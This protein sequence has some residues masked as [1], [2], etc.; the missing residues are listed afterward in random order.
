MKVQHD[1]VVEYPGGPPQA[2]KVGVDSRHLHGRVGYDLET[3]ETLWVPRPLSFKMTREQKRDAHEG[4]CFNRRVS[5]SLALDREIA[6]YNTAECKAKD[7]GDVELPRADVVIVFH[8]E[9]LSVLLRS[10]HSILNRTPPELLGEIVLFN[11][12]SN[13]TSHSWL[14]TEL[15]YHVKNLPKTRLIYGSRRRGLMMARIEGTRYTSSPV[16]VYLDSHIECARGWMEPMVYE[17]AKNRKTIVTPKIHTIDADS[18]EY[19]KNALGT[20][21]FSWSLGQ[22]HPPNQSEFEPIAS[23]VMA[24]GLFAADKSWFIDDLGGYD[25]EMRLYGGEEMEIGFKTWTCGGQ[26]LNV[27][28]S[29]VG[30]VFRTAEYWKGQV[31]KVPM[32]EILRNKRRTAMVW[33]DE[34]FEIFNIVSG[35]LPK[36]MDVG[37]LSMVWEVRKRLD[38]KPFK[39]F[40]DNVAV[41][42]WVPNLETARRGSLFS[43]G[44]VHQGGRATDDS[45]EYVDE[46]G[47]IIAGTCLDNLQTKDTGPVGTYGCHGQKGSQ[48]FLLDDGL[49]RVGAG[50]FKHCIKPKG[51]TSLEQTTCKSGSYNAWSYEPLPEL[52]FTNVPRNPELKQVPIGLLKYDNINCLRLEDNSELLAPCDKNDKYQLI[53]F[54]GSLDD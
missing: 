48:S 18:F 49:L 13:D 43:A 17:I 30:H 16:V 4:Y 9:D 15:P 6:D 34:Y 54:S 52:P 7:Y 14:F 22:T 12:A 38:C 21:S 3:G 36:G 19:E 51:K 33:L 1:D 31:Y 24:G 37:D 45:D 2:L 10:V 39:W 44:S 53:A 25:P 46:Q 8:N 42:V 29:R 32:E 35:N 11:D 28:C 20:L 50:G 5:E 41:D 27:P 26:L 47:R 23:P 40:L